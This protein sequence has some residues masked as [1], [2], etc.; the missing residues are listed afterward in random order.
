MRQHRGQ[1]GASVE[2]SGPHDFAVRLQALVLRLAN[3]HRIPRP[4]SVTIAI[5]PSC[6]RRTREEVPLICPS[7]QP[8]RLR[9]IG[10][11]GKSGR[12]VSK[13]KARMSILNRTAIARHRSLQRLLFQG[14]SHRG[15]TLESQVYRGDDGNDKQIKCDFPARVAQKHW[16]NRGLRQ[17]IAKNPEKN[18]AG[19]SCPA[20]RAL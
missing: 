12:V 7:P 10:T 19:G 13:R 8:K 1:L 17:K 18:D 6:G 14:F 20:Q 2:A 3:V 4:T 11:T 15:A 9:Q 16:K 5:R